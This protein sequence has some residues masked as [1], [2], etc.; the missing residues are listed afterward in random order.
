MS[1]LALITAHAAGGPGPDPDPDPPGDT[2]PYE[3]PATAPYNVP[4]AAI[5][6]TYEWSGEAI[7][8]DVIDFTTQHGMASW[9]GH[10]YWAGMTPYPGGAA[11]VENP[12]ILASDDGYTWVIPAGLTN[13]IDPAPGAGGYNSDTDL[14]YDPTT[15]R[16]WCFWREHNHSG[17][18]PLGELMHAAWSTNGSTWTKIDN[19]LVSQM[20]GN[21][22]A[23]GAF[24][25]P[26]VSRRPDGTWV[27]VSIGRPAL[28]YA[29]RLWTAPAPTGPWAEAGAAT[30]TWNGGPAPAGDVWHFGMALVDG[31]YY[32]L[33]DINGGDEH[34]YPATS[35]DG[36]AWAASTTPVVEARPGQ[37]DDRPYRSSLAPHENGAHMRVWYSANGT[38]GWRTGYTQVP[39]TA[40]PAPPA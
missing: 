5:T 8:P 24:L 17:A 13:P 27:M 26:A 37:W 14:E 38:T 22:G 15:G 2:T 3:F 19:V 36:L 6:P 23:S 7:H 35:T 9:N 1:L 31:V 28:G 18:A 34:V 20:P 30:F 40:W 10:R 16:L 32:G 21:E 25:S 39:L 12:S 33:I 29:P 11:G 4:V